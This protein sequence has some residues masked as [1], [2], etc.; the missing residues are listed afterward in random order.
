[1]T[2]I[3]NA[4]I[5]STM[6]GIEDHGILT[7]MITVDFGGS[8]QGFGGWAFDK[9]DGK[10]RVGTAWGMEWIRRLLETIG[11]EK[12]EDLIGQVVRI[13]STDGLI[14]SIGHIIEE[15]WFTPKDDLSNELA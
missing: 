2:E 1:M 3:R 10:T 15:K 5:K 8:Q 14:S 4:K 9:Y 7:A 13:R 6:L 11:V 12:W